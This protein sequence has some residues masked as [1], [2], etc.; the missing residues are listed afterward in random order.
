MVLRLA[1]LDDIPR[2]AALE[3]LP[4]FRGL[5]GSWPEQQHSETMV[6]KDARYFGTE[7]D[8]G[9]LEGFAILRGL[10]LGR[11]SIE[12]KRIVVRT[13]GRG[14]G[15]QI[16]EELIRIAFEQLGAHRL[17]LDV[18]EHNARA[19]HLYNILGFVQEG[20]LREAFYCD[21]KHYSL[22]LMSLLDREY[23]RNNRL[24]TSSA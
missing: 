4:E 12:I 3:R 7:A 22:I 14:L 24:Q 8:T 23:A 6:S 19:R 13:P 20:V 5:V 15:R 16:L 1:R 10:V 9:E 17:W 21:G 11:R 2:I 18:L